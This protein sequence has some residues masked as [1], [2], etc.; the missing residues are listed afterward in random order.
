M[1]TLL[2]VLMLFAFAFTAFWFIVYASLV[3][4]NFRHARKSPPERPDPVVTHALRVIST[5]FPSG[6]AV[7]TIAAITLF[8]LGA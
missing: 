5:G 2:T 4:E 3:S 6:L 8:A 1:D 7:L